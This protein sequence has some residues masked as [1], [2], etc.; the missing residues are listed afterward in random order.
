M[1]RIIVVNMELDYF[2]MFEAETGTSKHTYI[3]LD[4]VSLTHVSA[5]FTCCGGK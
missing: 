1:E 4:D 5:S 3:A 2:V